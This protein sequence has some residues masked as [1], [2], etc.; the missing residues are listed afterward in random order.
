M[1]REEFVAF[2]PQFAS[3]EPEIVLN[4]YISLAN[5][6]FSDFGTDTEEARRL[7]TAHRLT[8]YAKTAV[9]EGSASSLSVLASAG[10]AQQKLSSKKVGEVSVS[11]SSETSSANTSMADLTETTFGLQLLTLIRL[12]SMPVYVP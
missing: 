11:F 6:R 7:Y 5:G 3:F 9:P 4:E 8:L 10:S 1:T 12:H 2:Y